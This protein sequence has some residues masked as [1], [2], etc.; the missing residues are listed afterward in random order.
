MAMLTF[1]I[2]HK[3]KKSSF[4]LRQTQNIKGIKFF[5]FN[6]RTQLGIYCYKD[7]ADN[8]YPYS[9]FVVV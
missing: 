1:S 9:K 3:E 7:L 4:S 6:Y 8:Q 5:F 2:S